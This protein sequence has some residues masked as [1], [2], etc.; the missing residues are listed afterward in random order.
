MQSVETNH[1]SY[2]L[3]LMLM[4]LQKSINRLKIL[5]GISYSHFSNDKD[6]LH[7][8]NS[9]LNILESKLDNSTVLSEKNSIDILYIKNRTNTQAELDVRTYILQSAYTNICDDPTEISYQP[10]DWYFECFE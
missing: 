5:K 6:I 1:Y 9:E 8:Y 2:Y 7:A 4:E 3:T 10:Y